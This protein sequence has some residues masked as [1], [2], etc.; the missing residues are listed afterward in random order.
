[1]QSDPDPI[2]YH[3][4]L[5]DHLLG[6]ARYV[7]ARGFLV[8]IDEV[9]NALEGIP[10][11]DIGNYS[12]FLD[13]LRI[14]FSSSREQWISFDNLYAEYVK[15]HRKASNS[16]REDKQ[17]EKNQGSPKA[18]KGGKKQYQLSDIKQ[19]LFNKRRDP[20]EVPF[21]SETESDQISD[22]AFLK[23][24]QSEELRDLIKRLVK[25][26]AAIKSR[27]LITHRRK[28]M[29]DQRKLIANKVKKGDELLQLR[30]KYR[31]KRQSR[32]I[33]ICDVSKS[34]HLYS[35]F[36]SELVHSLRSTFSKSAVFVFN[37]QLFKLPGDW[38]GGNWRQTLEQ[39]EEIPGLW[40]GGTRIGQS[41]AQLLTSPDLP[42]WFNNK[43]K[44]IIYSDGWD[45][46][47]TD[48]LR[49]SMIELQEKSGL[50]LWMNPVF[51]HKEETEILGLKAVNPYVDILANVHNA[52]TLEDLIERL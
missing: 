4:S 44:V 33:L 12:S 52:K 21:Y 51:N 13:L 11:I 42:T 7:R 17:N 29:L 26:L 34:M 23:K 27:K 1:M 3:S 32:V 25:K 28:G 35:H 40:T 10:Y 31:K 24:E 49:E 47:D 6:F 48:L 37:T 36:I 2:T 38:L 22:L 45:T 39:L 50:I 20:L 46:G 9:S 43:T 41:L 8:G 19:W 18:R 30:F 5:T 16:K 15:E 14:N